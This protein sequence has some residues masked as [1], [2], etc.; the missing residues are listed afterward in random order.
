MFLDDLKILRAKLK[1]YRRK[2]KMSQAELADAIHVNPEVLSRRLN[3]R[4]DKLQ[5][6]DVHAIIKVLAERGVISTRS[7]ANQLNELAHC[8]D[9][10]QVAWGAP[11]LNRLANP[12][13]KAPTTQAQN[14]AKIR[15]KYLERVYQQYSLFSLPLGQKREISLQAVFLPLKLRQDPL[16]AEDSFL[17]GTKSTA[18]RT[19]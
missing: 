8:E 4:E 16:V 15:V 5:T 12:P 14:R 19:N 6:I 10:D 7:E 2:A 9:F 13:L 1:A 11:P 17:R 18:R 3:G